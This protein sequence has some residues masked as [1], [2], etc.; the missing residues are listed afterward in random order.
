MDLRE[1]I[2]QEIGGQDCPEFIAD[3]TIKLF[4]RWLRE[5]KGH[6]GDLNDAELAGW[7]FAHSSAANE[8]AA[9]R[10]EE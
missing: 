3:A 1:Q 2:M 10:K 8:L 9:M 4:E 7:Q 6:T 5:R